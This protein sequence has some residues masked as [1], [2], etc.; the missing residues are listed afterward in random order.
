MIAGVRQVTHIA[1][2][3]SNGQILGDDVVS[4]GVILRKPSYKEIGLCAGATNAYYT[5]TT[6]VYPDSKKTN[7]DECNRAQCACVASGL[8]F[9][10]KAQNYEMKNL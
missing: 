7:E 6:E 3:D 8:E 4:E 2:S 10:A 5:T 1:P 9:I